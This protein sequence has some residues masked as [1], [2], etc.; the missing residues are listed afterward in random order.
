MVRGGVAFSLGLLLWTP[1]HALSAQRWGH[2]Q[3]Q[4]I[5][6]GGNGCFGI[7]Y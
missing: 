7:S 5:V 1:Q 4:V 2:C 3:A 6:I